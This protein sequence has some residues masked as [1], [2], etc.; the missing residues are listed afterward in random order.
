MPASVAPAGN[1]SPQLLTVLFWIGVGLA[2]LAALILLVADGN[3]PLRFGAVLAILAVVLIGLSVALRAESGGG[4]AAMEDLHEEIERLRRE[5]RGEIVAAAQRGNQALDQAQRT[6]ESVTAMRRRLD[7]A[8]AGIAAAAG[9]TTS[10][11]DEPAGGRARVPVTEPHDEGRSRTEPGRAQP[12]GRDED[13]AAR[14][15]QSGTRYGA[16]AADRPGHGTD[17]AQSGV[18]GADRAQAGVYGGDRSQ[19][20]GYGGD[21]PQAG[22]Y[23]ASRAPE[24]ETRPEPRPV[25]VVHHTETVHVTT[26]HTIVDGGA[27]PA[28][29][30]YGGYAGRWSPAPDDRPWSGAE[31]EDRL[32][33][34]YRDADD[35]RPRAGYRDAD[36]DR[37]RAGYRDADDDRARPGRDERSRSAQAGW[38]GSAGSREDASWSGT[39]GGAHPWAGVGRAHGEDRGW[40]ARESDDRGRSAREDEDRGWSARQTDDDRAWSAREGDDRGWS[41]DPADDR[42]WSA[43]RDDVGRGGP[44]TWAGQA[45]RAGQGGP[46]AGQADRTGQGAWAGRG[47][48]SGQGDRAG[49]GEQA[50]DGWAGTDAGRAAA[51]DPDGDYWSELRTGNRW[52]AVRDDEHGREIRVGERRAA[53]HADGGGTEYRIEDRWASVRGSAGEPGG[54]WAEESRPALPA[55][56]V[57]VPDEWR[58]PAQRSGQPEWRQAE[59]EPARYGY[60]PRD[61]APRAGGTRATDRWR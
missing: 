36:D 43:A 34:G 6:E 2:P 31:P 15:P 14:R 41:A 3:G 12:A 19:A 8:A 16:A 52:A 10:P 17:R 13:E 22:V 25:G 44:G 48:W 26:R 7:A 39:A 58:P 27:D 59:P 4:A 47:N 45:D 46:W 33:A 35:D 51:D 18:Y 54:G 49:Y 40:P 24:P 28:G 61:D 37:P 42:S 38:S 1:R 29:S 5:L 32:R 9:L 11:A 30:R 23:G 50:A 55:G 57:P 56:G 60:P 53:V 21:R 20:G